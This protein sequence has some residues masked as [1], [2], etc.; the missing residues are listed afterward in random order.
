MPSF[1]GFVVVKSIVVPLA[2]PDA[3]SVEQELSVY[4]STV[5]PETTPD[6]VSVGD[7]TESE[8]LMVLT[9][10]IE[11]GALMVADL[12]YVNVAVEHAEVPE[13]VV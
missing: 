3:T 7:A 2:V 10:A 5:S 1:N 9:R 4:N 11:L 12:V 13:A 6:T 8:E